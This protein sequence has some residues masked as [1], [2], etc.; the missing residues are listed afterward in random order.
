MENTIRYCLALDLKDEARL[1]EE[2]K[3]WHKPGNIWKE[4]PE[5]IRQ[6]GILD[7]EI[8]LLHNHLF[9]IMET[10]PGF[11]LERDMEFLSQ[12]PRQNE[13]EEFVSRFQ[14]VEADNPGKKWQLM[15]RIFKL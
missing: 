7:M 14:K 3:Y 2:Y 6:S 10:I 15:E 8:Y 1:I 4:I 5:G 9:M 12:Q 11:D 13:W